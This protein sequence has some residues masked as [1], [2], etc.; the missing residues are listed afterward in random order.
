MAQDADAY[1]V[2]S[3]TMARLKSIAAEE[4]TE[5]VTIYKA[6]A[7][8]RRL[9]ILRLLVE[10]ELCVCDLVEIFDLEYSKLSY[11]LKQLREAGLVSTDREG[12]YVTYELTPTG[13][14]AA[15]G[16]AGFESESE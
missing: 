2:D 1:R 5:S 15:E 16:L 14:I 10:T 9:R 12:N 4:V 8:E 6:L 11:H 3:D 7:D 13:Q